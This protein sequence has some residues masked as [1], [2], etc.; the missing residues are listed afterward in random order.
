M[1]YVTKT[2]IAALASM[3]ISL[4][5]ACSAS[6][7]SLD[8]D[9][10]KAEAGDLDSANRVVTYYNFEGRNAPPEERRH[11]LEL[12]SSLNSAS[13]M[14]ALA[15]LDYSEGRCKSAIQLLMEANEQIALHGGGRIDANEDWIRQIAAD[16]EGCRQDPA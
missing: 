8:A 9:K 2:I 14:Q 7:Q 11:W 6:G 13:G 10:R 12:A 16:R 15:L 4:S 1:L 3:A 5:I